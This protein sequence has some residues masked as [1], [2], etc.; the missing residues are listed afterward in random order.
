MGVAETINAT[1]NINALARDPDALYASAL[2][3]IHLSPEVQAVFSPMA[4]TV[5]DMGY[6]IASSA[7]GGAINSLGAA[8]LTELAALVG[9]QTAQLAAGIAGGVATAVGEAIPLINVVVNM[10]MIAASIGQAQ[11]SASEAS[12]AASLKDFLDGFKQAGSGEGG[13]ILPAD[14]F[15]PRPF[16]WTVPDVAQRPLFWYRPA[17]PVGAALVAVTEDGNLWPVAESNLMHTREAWDK[18]VDRIRSDAQHEI[19]RSKSGRNDR[20]DDTAESKQSRLVDA[21]NESNTGISS[22]R[23]EIYRT[24]RMAI[25]SHSRDD[26]GGQA[27]FSLYMTLLCDDLNHGRL[28]KKFMIFLLQHVYIYKA[29]GGSKEWIYTGTKTLDL[30][31]SQQGGFR[32]TAPITSDIAYSLVDSIWAMATKFDANPIPAPKKAMALHFTKEAVLSLRRRKAFAGMKITPQSS[33]YYVLNS[34]SPQKQW[35]AG[36][37]VKKADLTTAMVY[38][39]QWFVI[40][41][42]SGAVVVSGNLFDARKTITGLP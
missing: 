34:W 37:W 12:E 14:L 33:T 17:H 29:E 11:T 19:E 23:K 16:I 18:A 25:G 36:R 26:Y 3:A 24:L 39:G 20:W 9:P 41:D 1:K 28:N 5:F 13:K 2:G 30:P 10:V 35:D 31:S 21:V 38:P 8:M 6:K 32:P 42:A 4:K 40:R 27:L 22:E 15:A 7:L